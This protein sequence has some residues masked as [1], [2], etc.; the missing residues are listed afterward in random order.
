MYVQD[1]HFEVFISSDGLQLIWGLQQAG[2]RAG[3]CEEGDAQLCQPQLQG[4]IVFQ[5]E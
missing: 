4:T 2:E 3:G 1:N 5:L